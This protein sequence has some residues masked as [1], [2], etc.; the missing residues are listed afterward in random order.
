MELMVPGTSQRARTVSARLPGHSRIS[1]CGGWR[2]VGACR[3]TSKTFLEMKKSCSF[4]AWC[5]CCMNLWFRSGKWVKVPTA[6]SGLACQG[7]TGVGWSSP[8]RQRDNVCLLLNPALFL[9]ECLKL[10]VVGD[11][12]VEQGCWLAAVFSAPVR[13]GPFHP[14]WSRQSP[15]ERVP[16][17]GAAQGSCGARRSWSAG[18]CKSRS[19]FSPSFPSTCSPAAVPN[20]LSFSSPRSVLWLRFLLMCGFYHLVLGSPNEAP[21]Q[22][23]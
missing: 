11:V 7:V 9:W 3:L 5:F 6:G 19:D 20:A 21:T 16:S 13:T 18:G 2:N 23:I 15:C 1:S 10:S 14:L 4:A 8:R 17:G 12:C 22:I